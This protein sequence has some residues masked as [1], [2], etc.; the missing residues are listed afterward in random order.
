MVGETRGLWDEDGPR[1][2]QS[3]AELQTAAERVQPEERGNE[4]PDSEPGKEFL[5]K[6][7]RIGSRTGR[8]LQIPNHPRQASRRGEDRTEPGNCDEMHAPSAL[9]P[10]AGRP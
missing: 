6:P 3:N 7:K 5:L 1:S 8:H 10:K 4:T 9:W 2:R